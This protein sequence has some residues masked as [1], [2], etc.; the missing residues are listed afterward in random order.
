MVHLYA[1]RHCIAA[2]LL[3]ILGASSPTGLV[4]LSSSSS[5][6][7]WVPVEDVVAHIPRFIEHDW[8]QT[9]AEGRRAGYGSLSAGRR[10]VADSGRFARSD[11]VRHVS[12]VADHFGL[13]FGPSYQLPFK[14]AWFAS[15]Q[16]SGRRLDCALWP[17][18]YSAMSSRWRASQQF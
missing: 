3:A 15:S 13:E 5:I 10:D 11:R 7:N 4:G 16:A 8:D 14:R 6:R 1:G 18:Y 17:D 9:S 12:V 2:R